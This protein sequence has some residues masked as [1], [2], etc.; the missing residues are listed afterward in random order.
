M[1]IGID[2]RVLDRKVTGTSRYLLNLLSEIPNQD[3][4]NEYYLLST[5]KHEVGDNYYKSII[6]NESRIPFKLYSPYWI[7]KDVPAIAK[8]YEIDIMLFPNV[9]VPLVNLG[10]CKSVSVVHDVIFKIYKEYYPF[11]Y[12]QYLSF[13]LPRS[14]KKSNKII[15]VSQLSKNDIIK[16][17]GTNP[18]KIEVVYNTASQSFKPLEINLEEK[19]RILKKYSISDRFLL[20]VGVVEKRKNISLLIKI[21]DELKSTGSNLKLLIIGKPGYKS[22]IL[23]EEIRNREDLISYSP[24]VEDNDLM[25][26]YNLAFAFIFPSFYEGFGIPPLEAMQSSTPVLVS[27]TPAMEEV[28]GNGGVMHNPN[29]YNAFVHNIKKLENDERFYLTMKAKA[30]EQSKKFTIKETTKKLIDVLNNCGSL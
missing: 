6:T 13:Y 1:K 29:D 19:N 23:L 21:M 17:Y 10:K 30:L 4:N 5:K 3:D 12:R 25:Y 18:D 2:A 27:N 26:I 20:Y 9:L 28:V 15:T 16:Y 11:F 22:N 24:Y 7:N 8:K 14:I